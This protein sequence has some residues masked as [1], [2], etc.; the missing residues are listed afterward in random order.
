MRLLIS[1]TA[2]CVIFVVPNHAHAQKARSRTVVTNRANRG[3]CPNKQINHQRQ[4]F[5]SQKT[6][7]NYQ[8]TTRTATISETILSYYSDFPAL[9]DL[10]I[11]CQSKSQP[12]EHEG[13]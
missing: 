1:I 7:G 5:G 4:G 2:M 6:C 3:L 8:R 13:M 9:T 11:V 12:S 10:N